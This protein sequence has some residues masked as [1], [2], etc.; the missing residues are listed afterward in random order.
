MVEFMLYRKRILL[1]GI[2]LSIGLLI[3]MNAAIASNSEIEFGHARLPS[4]AE[5]IVAPRSADG[6]GEKLQ[7]MLQAQMNQQMNQKPE[8]FIKSLQKPFSREVWPIP[9]HI[10][11]GTSADA[12]PT[13]CDEY[14]K[15][16]F[17]PKVRAIRP[18]IKKFRIVAR[19]ENEEEVGTCLYHW[20]KPNL[21]SDATKET[22]VPN[23]KFRWIEL[24]KL[25]RV[26][27]ARTMDIRRF[28]M[29]KPVREFVLWV[30]GEKFKELG[31]FR[32]I[33]AAA[34]VIYDQNGGSRS[35][36]FVI[37]E[38]T[39]ENTYKPTGYRSITIQGDDGE[40]LQVQQVKFHVGRMVVKFGEAAKKKLG[41]ENYNLLVLVDN[42]ALAEHLEDGKVD[43][44]YKG[45]LQ[46]DSRK[47]IDAVGNYAAAK[48]DA[49]RVTI[50]S[51]A[52]TSGKGKFKNMK[53]RVPVQFTKQAG[54]WVA[55][56]FKK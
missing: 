15:Y 10:T 9:M 39:G 19:D 17:L 36:A 18:N 8:D 44:Y 45:K 22:I 46:Q 7:K 40:I 43:D 29:E 47:Y 32:Y 23:F 21:V 31:A 38:G 51:I 20:D 3:I 42:P 34:R 41:P 27:V 28:D 1:T 37:L 48:W 12:L 35:L 4:G 30:P 24:G 16:A 52:R 14:I 50:I 33:E 6:F 11:N 13:L 54:E 25:G 26:R 49:Q 5:I 55:Q 56:Q 2:S 53:M